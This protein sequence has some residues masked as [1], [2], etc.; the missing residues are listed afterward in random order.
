MIVSLVGLLRGS[1][2]DFVKVQW[3]GAENIARAAADS[4][5]RVIH[6]SAIGA[7]PKSGISYARTKGLG[8]EAVLNL[9]PDATIVRPS[10]IF[11]PEDDFFNVS[12]RIIHNSGN[13]MSLSLPALLA[14]VSLPA[15]FA[16]LWG[17]PNEISAGLRWRYRS[18]H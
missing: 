2:D 9:C 5:S 7:D 13:H 12:L 15:F 8:E 16:S 1:E 18:R 6:I 4:R 10:I 11:G 14:P 17:W 3:K